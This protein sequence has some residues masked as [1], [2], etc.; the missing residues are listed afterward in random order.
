MK[1]FSNILLGI[2]IIT[3][4]TEEHSIIRIV[5]CATNVENWIVKNLVVKNAR[6]RVCEI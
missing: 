1:V 4:T 2:T 5:Q 6:M 3:F